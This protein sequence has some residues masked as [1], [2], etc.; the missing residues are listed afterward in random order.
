MKNQILLI[1]L[2]AWSVICT[3]Q[4]N[5]LFLTDASL[6][7][8][9]LFTVVQGTT[10]F[11]G[12]VLPALKLDAS[13]NLSIGVDL[14]VNGVNNKTLADGVAIS[15]SNDNL[16][17]AAHATLKNVNGSTIS[18]AD[19]DVINC[20]YCIVQCDGCDV[21]STTK[22]IESVH[23]T[24]FGNKVFGSF[25][26]VAGSNIIV[27]GSHITARGENYTAPNE[28][29]FYVGYNGKILFSV[30]Y[31]QTTTTATNTR[32]VQLYQPL[33][34]AVYD[35]VGRFKGIWIANPIK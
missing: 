11:K 26:D 28:P 30:P 17:N 20:N 33:K 32:N 4:P 24:G 12:K 1:V 25:C 8:D 16:I 29:G 27:N 2:I 5:K 34:L 22:V 3:A 18:G 21:G 15:N 14:S 23:V 9:S 35:E 6:R 7:N 13:R 19:N 10:N 31:N